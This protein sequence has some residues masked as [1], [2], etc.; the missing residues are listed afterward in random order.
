MIKKMIIFFTFSFLFFALPVPAQAAR[1]FPNPWIPDSKSNAN[2]HGTY[3]DGITIDGLSISG[4]TINIHNATGELVRKVQ[5]S[6]GQDR[7][8]WDG[9]NDRGEYVASGVYIWV[10]KDGGTKSGKVVVIR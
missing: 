6:A 1:A 3:N 10:V 7:G 4:G 2:V 5:W 9:K 8:K